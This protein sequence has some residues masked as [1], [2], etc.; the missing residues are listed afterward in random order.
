MIR[1]I[2]R[3]GFID[4]EYDL[5]GYR[6]TGLLIT[7]TCYTGVLFRLCIPQLMK[8]SVGIL[9]LADGMLGC[10]QTVG[11]GVSRR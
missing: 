8:M 7:G 6:Y 1:T 9:E 4:T 2:W 3:R 5:S 10:K 11:W